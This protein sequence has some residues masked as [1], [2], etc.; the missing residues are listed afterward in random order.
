MGGSAIRS[1]EKIW[2]SGAK[3]GASGSAPSPVVSDSAGQLRRLK[4]T[5]RD[6]AIILVLLLLAGF[7]R[8]FQ[9]SHPSGFVF[10]E[11]YYARDA[12]L[13]LG[14]GK[15]TCGID[16]EQ[17]HVHPQLGK[18]LIAAGIKA[19]GYNSLGWRVVA[20]LFGT[21]LVL[22]TYL[23]VRKL[24]WDRWIAG[25]AG[26]LVATDFLLI[27]QSR[28]GML[29]IFLTTFVALGFAFL[30]VDRERILRLKEGSRESAIKRGYRWR[31][32]A[33]AAFGLGV[34]IKWAAAW[35]LA[36]AGLLALF[37]SLSLARERRRRL[38]IAPEEA[39]QLPRLGRELIV[40][41]LSL[42]LVPV[43]IY[44]ASYLQWFIQHNFD[45]RGFVELHERMV[46][47]HLTLR[48]R[49]PYASRAWAWPVILQP[50][51]Y[52]WT[53][54]PKPNYILAFGNPA[55]WWPALVAGLWLLARSFRRWRGERVIGVG[56]ATLYLPWLAVSRTLYF[57]YMTPVVPFMMAALALLLGDLRKLGRPGR[58]MVRAYL[59]LGVGALVVYFYP[60]I[61]GTDGL[62]GLPINPPVREFTPRPTF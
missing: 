20:G 16:Q 30:A 34:A 8:F 46:N 2:E 42:G 19:F 54:G 36:G 52:W 12:C 10:D 18:W 56:W 21:M 41:A 62:G 28:V 31:F 15:K 45:P 50:I 35:P 40:L 1:S 37:W 38:R 27:L 44:V 3:E 49:H 7:L 33:G 26:F 58:L 22:I 39:D 51:A 24:F 32:A 53:L 4:W 25:A 14:L 48:A 29:D 11:I 60:L 47:F 6:S 61:V 23:L 55:T 43:V 9:L 57:F 59:I 17:S 13:Y 5:R